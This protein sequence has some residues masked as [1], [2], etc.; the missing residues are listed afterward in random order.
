[1]NRSN[2]SHSWPALFNPP[3]GLVCVRA[4]ASSLSSFRSFVRVG[5]FCFVLR[6]NC[7]IR[8]SCHFTV[9]LWVQNEFSGHYQSDCRLNIHRTKTNILCD[10]AFPFLCSFLH[11]NPKINNEQII[12]YYL[13]GSSPFWSIY[14]C[15][16]LCSFTLRL[17]H[18]LMLIRS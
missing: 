5:I 10:N 15:G 13:P 12:K 11:F 17:C 8:F 1:M 3:H 18:Q 2:S 16:D 7:Q 14:R 6:F 9:C 4:L